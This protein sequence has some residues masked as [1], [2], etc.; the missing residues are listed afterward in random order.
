MD[1]I[2]QLEIRSTFERTRELIDSKI[3]WKTGPENLFRRSVL[4]EILVQMKDLLIKSEKYLE[5]RI[6]FKDDIIQDDILKISDIT[7][8]ISNF[9]DAACHNDSFRRKF[10]SN[11]MSF[12]EIRGK[13]I[14][15]QIGDTIIGS[16]Y[17]DDIAFNMG[18]NILYMKRHIERAFQELELQFKP[19][20]DLS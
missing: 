1:L 5:K 20:L 15:M 13:G 11:V 8:L 18:N 2:L 4:I 16:A 6:S 3:I 10:G 9:R 19:F 17:S 14:L 12:N 7:D